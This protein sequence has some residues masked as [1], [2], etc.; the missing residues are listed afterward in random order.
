MKHIRKYRKERAEEE[1]V[2]TKS[3]RVKDGSDDEQS[4]Y[5]ADPSD[6]DSSDLGESEKEEMR[7]RKSLK[8]NPG[9]QSNMSSLKQAMYLLGFIVTLLLFCSSLFAFLTRRELIFP[10]RSAPKYVFDLV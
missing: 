1:R 2:T 7:N 8:F 5:D 4:L 3:K 9:M 10:D 6:L